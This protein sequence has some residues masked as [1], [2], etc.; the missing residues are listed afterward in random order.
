MC[1]ACFFSVFACFRLGHAVFFRLDAT[2]DCQFS[3]S[4]LERARGF[5]PE[6]LMR[7]CLRLHFLHPWRLL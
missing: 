3:A 1:I 7:A 4:E 2:M 6:A 5:P